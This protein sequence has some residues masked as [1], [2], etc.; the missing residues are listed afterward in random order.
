MPVLL[1]IRVSAGIDVGIPVLCL[2]LR[3]TMSVCVGLGVCMY[4]SVLVYV[5][6][7]AQVCL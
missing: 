2:S 5:I 7:S 4:I 6:V 1:C 3:T